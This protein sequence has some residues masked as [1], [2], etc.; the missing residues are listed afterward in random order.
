[1]KLD[2]SPNSSVAV[3]SC[4]VRFVA[5]TPQKALDQLLPH[6]AEWVCGINAISKLKRIYKKEGLELDYE[7]QG[8]LEAHEEA[9]RS[10]GQRAKADPSN[11]QRVVLVHP[12]EGRG[13]LSQGF[14]ANPRAYG[15]LGQ[16]GHNGLDYSVQ[17]GT[18][19]VAMADGIVRFA[20]EGVDE[21]LMGSAA[22]TCVLVSS[23]GFLHGYA[24]LSR[25]YVQNGSKVTAGSVLG[26]SGSTGLSTGPHLHAELIPLYDMVPVLSNGYMGRIDPAP[27]LQKQGGLLPKKGEALANKGGTPMGAGGTPAKPADEG[28]A[29][30]AGQQVAA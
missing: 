10:V 20:G 19:V 12:L 2:K 4:G 16:D 27:Y 18:P 25:V 11:R 9:R 5:H 29:G 15:R 22:G 30:D 17:E 28:T 24:H 1:M 26:L 21:I 7:Q 8:L 6:V 3:C 23:A 14:G 13:V